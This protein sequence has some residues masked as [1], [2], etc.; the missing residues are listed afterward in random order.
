MK[1]KKKMNDVSVV[2]VSWNARDYL[3]MCLQ[4]IA[5]AS[6][7]LAVEVIVVDNASSD[8][9]PEMVEK[10]FPRVR[11]IQTGANLGFAGGNN[12]GIEHATGKYVFLINSDVEVGEDTFGKLVGYLDENP[13]IGL[14]GPKILSADGGIQRSSMG[15]PTVE[16]SLYRAIALDR[17]FP[18]S[19]RFGSQLMTFWDHNSTRDVDVVNGCFWAAR[20]DAIKQVGVLDDRFFMYGE[21]VDWCRRFHQ[22]GWRVVFYPSAEVIHYGAGSSSNA[23]QRFYV[24]LY[25][26]KLMMFQKH[27]S[28]VEATLYRMILLFHQTIRMSAFSV[29]WIG[30][31]SQRKGAAKKVSASVACIRSLALGGVSS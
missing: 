1:W 17:L 20:V 13:D 9:S 19:R 31:P 21:D 8:G 6:S 29:L 11:L 4:S 15:F 2:I 5:R 3:K 14:L 12:K 28:P 25:R 26:S 24:Q 10:E 16:N 22:Q 7:G 30:K 23:P 27:S 18:N